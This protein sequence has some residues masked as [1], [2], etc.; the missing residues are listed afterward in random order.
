MNTA[1]D[2]SH[3]APATAPSLQPAID[4]A[5]ARIAPTWPLDRFIAVN[6]YWGHLDQPIAAA[7]AELAALSGSPI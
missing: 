4:Q 7:A 5:C 6:P 2:T 1:L 3:P